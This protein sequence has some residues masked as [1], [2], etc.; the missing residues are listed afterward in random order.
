MA[1]KTINGENLLHMSHCTPKVVLIGTR[2]P[3]VMSCCLIK[4]TFVLSV[5]FTLLFFMHERI[6]TNEEN[7]L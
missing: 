7:I 2:A 4:F 6:K 5:P 3:S 1:F